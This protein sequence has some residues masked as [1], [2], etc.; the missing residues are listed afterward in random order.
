MDKRVLLA[1]MT[2]TGLLGALAAAT[3]NANAAQAKGGI[4]R[5]PAE[6][7]SGRRLTSAK[8]SIIAGSSN[9]NTTEQEEW[10]KEV[11]RRKESSRG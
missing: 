10:N 6:S 11:A 5:K 8:G 3:F 2:S 4:Q 9:Q 1:A 7:K